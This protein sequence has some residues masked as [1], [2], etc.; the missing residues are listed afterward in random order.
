[1]YVDLVNCT[2]CRAEEIKI[3]KGEKF[4]QGVLL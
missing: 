3:I 2:N 1:M 4:A